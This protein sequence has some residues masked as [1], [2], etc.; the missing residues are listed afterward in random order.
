MHACTIKLRKLKNGAQ[1]CLLTELYPVKNNVTWWS[2]K[3][4]MGK[5]YIRTES[6]PQTIP[7]LKE[8]ILI[9]TERRKLGELMEHISKFQ[10]ITNNLQLKGILLHDL[11]YFFSGVVLNYIVMDKYTY[12]DSESVNNHRF[13]SGIVK[14]PNKEFSSISRS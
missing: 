6:S 9:P 11:R 1:F 13:E 10:S 12:S 7:E 4:E 2:G 5:Q 3:Y 14:I 8:Y